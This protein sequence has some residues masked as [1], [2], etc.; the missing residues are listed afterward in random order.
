MDH[1]GGRVVDVHAIGPVLGMDGRAGRAAAQPVDQLQAAGSV[2]ARQPQRRGRQAAGRQRG[3]G[4][5][6]HA[7]VGAQGR[8]R[9]VF[10]NPVAM[11]FAIDGAGRDEHD[12]LEPRGIQRIQH[13]CQA[14]DEDAAVGGGIARAGRGQVD[15][16]GHSPG[17]RGKAAGAGDVAPQPADALRAVGRRIAPQRMDL[18]AAR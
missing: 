3:L 12:A 11:V 7:A 9:R 18:V 16:A 8:G 2:Q 17:Q 6:Q 1:G 10:G 14:V 15:Q 5:Q 4:F 13:V